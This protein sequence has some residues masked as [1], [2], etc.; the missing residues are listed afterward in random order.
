MEINTGKK[1][2]VTV[3]LATTREAVVEVSAANEEEA[4]LRALE[5]TD[6][7]LQWK[8]TH[9]DFYDGRVPDGVDGT[10]FRIGR[11]KVIDQRITAA[12]KQKRDE[13]RSS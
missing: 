4:Q 8:F 2:S 6:S 7:D 10:Y 1:F 11:I 9:M 5:L 12:G 3:L 13:A